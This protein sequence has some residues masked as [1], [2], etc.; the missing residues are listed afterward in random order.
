MRYKLEY[1]I[2]IEIYYKLTTVIIIY[3]ITMYNI[4]RINMDKGGANMNK[5]A[6]ILVIMLLGISTFITG[7]NSSDDEIKGLESNIQSLEIQLINL[8]KQLEETTH[9]VEI[10]EAE[11]VEE[12]KKEVSEMIQDAI[13]RKG[14]TYD[15]SEITE[16]HDKTL[17]MLRTERETYSD[18]YYLYDVKL[19]ELLLIPT[20]GSYVSSYT[21]INE[22]HVVFNMIGTHSETS[23]H[24][25][26][27][28][29]DYKK[30]I[31]EDGKL[32]FYPVRKEMYHSL[33]EEI[34]FGDKSGHSITD[35]I[36][37]LQGI[38][39]GF[40]PQDPTD[41]T[42]FAGTVTPPITKTTY[43]KDTHQYILEFED[44]IIDEALAQKEIF[45]NENSGY[46]NSIQLETNENTLLMVINLKEYKG[47]EKYKHF[48]ELDYFTIEILDELTANIS[49]EIKFYNEKPNY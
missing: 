8:E 48:K 11:P 40:G 18:S 14:L 4:F 49:I 31:T 39:I 43:N 23:Y 25:V 38:Q 41:S 46:I 9:G 6:K 42:Y 36:V 35:I 30:I 20:Y 3:E 1:Y 15:D 13:N 28:I 37:T 33:G 45:V 10:D 26:P 34:H 47:I 16:Y 19:D 24:N 22:N 32:E 2:Y 21:I 29:C 12:G 27:F 5:K 17:Y 7:C 44:T